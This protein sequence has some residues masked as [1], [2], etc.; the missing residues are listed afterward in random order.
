MKYIYD[1][2]NKENNKII[3][4][5]EEERDA[6]FTEKCPS[7]FGLMD[8]ECTLDPEDDACTRCWEAAVKCEVSTKSTPTEPKAMI[9]LESIP[10]TCNDCPCFGQEFGICQVT[11]RQYDGTG[12][13]DGCPIKE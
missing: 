10:T 12:R 3:F 5:C 9:V 11:G 2:K 13:M 7:N 1:I 6:V 4:E 8:S